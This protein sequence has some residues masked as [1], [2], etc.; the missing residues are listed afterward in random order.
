M[1]TII[2]GSRSITDMARVFEIL[3][4]VQSVLIEHETLITE[5][6]SGTAQGV[7]ELGEHWAL[8]N[9][10]PVKR[11]PAQWSKHGKAAG[12]IRN[13]EMGDY[14][15]ALIAIWDGKSTGTKHMID[16]MI[17][18]KK[19]VYVSSPLEDNK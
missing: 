2:A 1:K 5:V 13:A 9:G 16:Y 11:F 15:D 14:A 6:V 10:I 7:D 17:K 18:K 12:P 4:L 3:D 19:F 8:D